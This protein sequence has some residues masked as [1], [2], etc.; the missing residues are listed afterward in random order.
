MG[1]FQGS[2]VDALEAV[3]VQVASQ[4]CVHIKTQSEAAELFEGNVLV[5]LRTPNEYECKKNGHAKGAINLPLDTLALNE[6]EASI[7]RL[8]ATDNK[9][10]VYCRSGYR[11]SIACSIL[12]AHGVDVIDIVGGYTKLRQIQVP[13]TAV[14]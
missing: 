12:A 8:P 11:S 13:T 3:G 9:I 5:D 10:F 1:F 4:A 6:A 7:S 14:L 2:T